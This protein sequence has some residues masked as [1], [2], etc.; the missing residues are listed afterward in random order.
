MKTSTN[1]FITFLFLNLLIAGCDCGKTPPPPPDGPKD[2]QAPVVAIQVSSLTTTSASFTFSATDNVGVTSLVLSVSG[3]QQNVLGQSSATVSGL[4]SNTDYTAYLTAKDAAGNTGNAQVSFKTAARPSTWFGTPTITGA[5]PISGMIG[6]T[7]SNSFTITL[8]NTSGVAKTATFSLDFGNFYI[9]MLRYQ[10][11]NAP[12]G[13]GW[14]ALPANNGKVTFSNFSLPAGS[15][16][17]KAV[18]AS[19]PSVAHGSAINLSFTSLDDG[20]GGGVAASG[21]QAPVSFGTMD[22]S[23]APTQLITEWWGYSTD[24]PLH[25][26]PNESGSIGN[27]HVTNVKVSGPAPAKV[28]SLKLYN[29]YGNALIWYNDTW[30]YVADLPDYF[31]IPSSAI[32]WYGD[33]VKITMPIDKAPIS[34]TSMT[35]F[36]LG[37]DLR[38]ASTTVAFNSGY[39]TPG[40]F[41]LVLKTKYDLVIQNSSGQVIDISDAVIKQESTPLSN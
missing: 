15:T 16:S 3:T 35:G 18:F 25:L 20:E 38:N 31:S 17:L 24:Q 37:C 33:Y 29:P 40:I 19:K 21:W 39:I 5:S 10:A 4:T 13:T 26:Y 2:T 22:G 28:A 34:N 41:G 1:L 30:K 14:T 6:N 7:I 12:D 27:Y 23:T 9:K 8:S 36:L 11:A 32:V